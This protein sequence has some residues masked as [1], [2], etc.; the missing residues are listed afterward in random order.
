MDMRTGEV[1]YTKNSNER[2][3]MASTTKIT[4]AAVVLG[5]A[6]LTELARASAAAAAVGETTMV[7]KKGE[8][9]TIEQLLYG[10]LL[11]SANDAA[12][13]LAEHVGGSQGWFVSMMNAL[14]RSLHMTHT[15]YANPHGLD[16]S[17]HYTSAHDLAIV[18]RYAMR[19]PVFRRIVAT[20]SY[21]IPA[22]R[23]NA[24]HWLANINRVM[25]WYP[26]VDGVKPGGTD[27]AG[28]C[29]VVSVWRNGRHLLAV[30]LNTPNLWVDIR[31]LLDYGSRDFHW[32]P[33]PVWSDSP[34]LSRSGGAADRAWR[35]YFGAGHYIRGAFLHYFTT[36]GGLTTM[37]YPRTEIVHDG[38][39]RI[40]YFQAGALAYDSRYHSVYPVDLGAAVMPPTSGN[41]R[42][43]VAASFSR[44]Y[45]TLG[46]RGV[47]GPATT[48]PVSWAGYP[49]QFFAF[50]AL[51]LV[52]GAAMVV[53]LGDV[54]LRMRGWLPAAGVGNSFPAGI[55][56]SVSGIASRPPIPPQHP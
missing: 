48:G 19:N 50:G 9:L 34:A 31:N 15:R 51:A 11:N 20:E 23:H 17:G 27:A 44:A 18:A 32:E 2:L 45:R 28:L 22:T 56:T 52:N 37:G 12:V 42:P 6:R 24:E 25:Y 10:L 36:H 26:G 43:R 5:H 53:P 30:L 46:G 3:P 33:A 38:E 21:H 54:V 8:R 1:L 4:T 14:A 29:Q 55:E 16:A 7:L 13:T 35:Y 40:Q 39:Q 47:L 49:T 41:P